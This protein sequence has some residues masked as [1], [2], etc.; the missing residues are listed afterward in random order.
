M[1]KLLEQT[2]SI[3]Q[4][5]LLALF[6]EDGKAW[7]RQILNTFLERLEKKGLA[8]INDYM[9]IHMAVAAVWMLAAIF[10]LLVEL[11]HSIKTRKYVVNC[12]HHVN[13]KQEA[14]E[15]ERRMEPCRLTQKVMVYYVF[16]N[17]ENL[18]FGLFRPVILCGAAAKSP[19]AGMVLSHEFVH[20]KRFDV[21]WK[22]LFRLVVILHRWN[23]AVWLIRRNLEWSCECSCD[24]IV[25]HG[26]TKEERKAYRWRE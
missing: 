18:T 2:E 15:V 1:E 13:M 17:R 14:I 9:K 7:K 10:I 5:A 16:H 11:Y 12:I 4:S 19:E 25:L 3:K 21:F 26:K 6:M 8:E 23:P 24:D 20:I 22:I